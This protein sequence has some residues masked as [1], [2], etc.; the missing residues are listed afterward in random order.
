MYRIRGAKG[1]KEALQGTIGSVLVNQDE[2]KAS[3]ES[4]PEVLKRLGELIDK[5]DSF[6]ARALKLKKMLA[7]PIRFW[8]EKTT[9]PDVG[10]KV[11][12]IEV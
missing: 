1:L 9:D 11:E 2:L 6:T 4:N 10:E 12:D 8:L 5:L 7:H 3:R